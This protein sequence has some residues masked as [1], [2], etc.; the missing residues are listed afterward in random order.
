MHDKFSVSYIDD[1]GSIIV[2]KSVRPTIEYEET[3]LGNKKGAKRQFRY[4]N[5]HIREYGDYYTV[6]M[7]KVDPRKDP[8]GHLLID[9]PEF[10]VGLMSAI[11]M[12]KLV[13][14]AFNDN[15][16]TE[17]NKKRT[18]LSNGIA[19]GCIMTSAAIT[20]YMA[21][22]IFKKLIRNT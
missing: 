9:A 21:S 11:S 15:N 18:Q 7:D 13:G 2:P 3:L 6:H 4:K 12:G 19:A 5:L 1:E 8:F 16:R 17:D 14:F 22:N 20:S 10:L